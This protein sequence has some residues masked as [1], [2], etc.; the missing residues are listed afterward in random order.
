MR[1]P[2][3]L[4]AA[5]EVLADIDAAASSSVADALKAWGL[6]NRY[7]GSGDRAAIGN[8]VYDSL[9]K[10][11]SHAWATGAD[12][13]RALI[14][15]VVVRDWGEPLD[16]MSDLFAQDAHAPETLS[17][18]G[19]GAPAEPSRSFGSERPPTFVP[20][21]R[22]GHCPRG[23][24]FGGDLVAEGQGDGRRARRSTCG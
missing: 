20:T 7:A 8:L 15:S 22:N 9:R 3:R 10:R 11:A 16:E 14:L 23:C 13:P 5:I 1:L 6:D 24:A 2:G 19:R 12:T 18:G 21:C 17:A 4:A